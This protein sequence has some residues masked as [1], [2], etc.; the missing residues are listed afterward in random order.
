MTEVIENNL[1]D[2]N[3]HI[4]DT[5]MTVRGLWKIYGN[6]PNRVMEPEFSTKSKEEILEEL[7]NVVALQDVSFDV[8][9]GKTLVVMGLSGS[10][11][12]TLVRCLIRL[13]EPTAGAIEV[14]GE[15]ILQYTEKQLGQFHRS[16]TAMVFQHFGLMPH[17][18]VES[19]VRWGLEVRDL[20]DKEVD[21][22]TAEAIERVGLTSWER[23]YP[24]ELSGG[25][26]QR[27]GLARALA[28]DPD[29]LLMDEPFSGLD[30]LIR[31]QMQDE[32]LRLQSELHKTI[33]FITH[34]LNEAL[35]LGDR[36]VIMRDGRVIQNSVPKDIVLNPSDDYVAEFTRNV[37]A[38][39]VLT[40]GIVAT[41]PQT[42][43]L[44]DTSPEDAA[45]EMDAHPSATTGAAQSIA[46]IVDG[47]G[48]YLGAIDRGALSDAAGS[49][50]DLISANIE[51]V[52]EDASFKS[53][54]PKMIVDHSPMAVVDENGR[55]V[56]EILP[57]TV[58]NHLADELN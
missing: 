23:A 8:P 53:I 31:T 35:K 45:K 48:Q 4:Q 21:A 49:L 15:D 10:G 47:E 52:A 17:R 51:S 6:T 12:S 41:E 25:M 13:I 9:S 37:Q 56:G 38:A 11:K 20:S 7:G 55:F 39:E 1:K 32:L 54:L 40:A 5:V 58:A 22:R 19:N 26:Q 16:K 3:S 42:K 27:V 44:P 33:I 57:E 43:L 34:D 46:F 14:E 2:E 50:I 24:R 18:N 36:I 28:V 29:I 30:P